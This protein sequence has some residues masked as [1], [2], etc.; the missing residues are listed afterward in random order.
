MSATVN[1]NINLDHLPKC[2]KCEKGELLPIIDLIQ[3]ESYYCKGWI[4]SNCDHNIIWRLGELHHA[5]VIEDKPLA[6]R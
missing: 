4:C 1:A 6:K 5:V 2:P 3:G